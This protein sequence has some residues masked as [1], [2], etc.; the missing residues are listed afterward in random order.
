[1]AEKKKKILIVED[2]KNYLWILQQALE[3]QGFDVITAENGE[4]GA[5]TAIRENPDLILLDITMPKLD[6]IGASKKIRLAG[7]KSPIL[8]LTN[9]SDLK[10][11][12]DAAETA[13]D[14]IVKA[15][16]SVDDIVVRVKER[17]NVWVIK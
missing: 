14:Y 6:G 7:I 13:T 4:V 16:V 10:H 1:M 8:F 2:S 17:L 12:S 15:E 3:G 5:E 11:I 9:M